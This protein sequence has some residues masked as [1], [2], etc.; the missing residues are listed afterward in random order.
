ML[1]RFASLT[2]AAE[3][4]P[5]TIRLLPVGTYAVTTT[6]VVVRQHSVYAA[7]K[8]L[9]MAVSITVSAC[10]PGATATDAIGRDL[11]AAVLAC[12][13][14]S[15]V[16]RGVGCGGHEFTRKGL[17]GCVNTSAAVR[18]L[19]PP[20]L[21]QSFTDQRTGRCPSNGLQEVDG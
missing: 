17:R 11:T 3:G 15:C 1:D 2:G 4:A 10:E 14:P 13:P 6:S 12:P 19:S 18:A 16:Q 20:R 7:C 8:A 9:G 21:S 5:P